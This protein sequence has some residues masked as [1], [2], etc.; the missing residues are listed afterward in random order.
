MTD[1]FVKRK[2]S[3]TLPTCFRRWEY[4]KIEDLKTHAANAKAKID[5]E[6][7]VKLHVL[8]CGM[9]LDNFIYYDHRNT[10]VFNWRDYASKNDIVTQEQFDRFLKKVDYTKLP[11]GIEFQLK[12]A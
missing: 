1:S 8:R 2:I 3:F 9:P 6:L 12:T 11:S 4:P 10:G 5:Q 7:A